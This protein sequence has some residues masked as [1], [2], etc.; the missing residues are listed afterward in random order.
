MKRKGQKNAFYSNRYGDV[1]L[2]FGTTQS[3]QLG[4]A[5]PDRT[6]TQLSHYSG[7]AERERKRERLEELQSYS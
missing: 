4:P 3:F 6:P 2:E 1:V 5:E 7:L